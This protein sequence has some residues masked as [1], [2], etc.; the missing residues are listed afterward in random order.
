MVVD[1]GLCGCIG[2]YLGQLLFQLFDPRCGFGPNAQASGL[3]T[4]LSRLLFQF[5]QPVSSIARQRRLH[6][7]QQIVIEKIC[8]FLRLQVHDPYRPKS[9]SVSY[10]HLT[11][12]TKRIV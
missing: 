5:V 1:L 9:R 6:L 4:S 12:P 11:L 2:L 7:G 8:D 10:T 3:L